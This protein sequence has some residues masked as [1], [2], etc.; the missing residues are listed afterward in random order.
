M[1]INKSINK[2][3]DDLAARKPT[4]GGGSAAG[5]CGALG[6]ALL[7]MVCNFTIGNQKYK[8]VQEDIRKSLVALKKIREEFTALVDED[9]RIYSAISSAFKTKDKKNI[10]NALRDGYL[11]SLK[12]C[13]LSNLGLQIALDISGK[14]N[15]NL[16][17]DI[18][19][20]AELL[21][22][23]FNSGIFNSEINLK[24]IE[25]KEFVEKERIVLDALG[26]E[27]G[28]LY[29]GAIT[30]TKEKMG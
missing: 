25:D 15:P 28:I 18:G 19:C 21:G 30:K 3:I 8:A 17:T 13:R 24:G 14:G 26:T 4:P 11:V 12:M 29:K 10:D 27:K 5:V 1:H 9:A 23:A 20:G 16:I 2:Y 7:E 22:A 6:I